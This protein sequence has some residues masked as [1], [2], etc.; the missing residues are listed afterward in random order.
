MGKVIKNIVFPLL[1]L[2]G[3]WFFYKSYQLLMEENNRYQTIKGIDEKVIERL[4]IS[5]HIQLHY[6]AVRGEYASNW[7]SLFNFVRTDSIYTVQET[8]TIKKGPQG[9]ELIIERDTIGVVQAYDSLKNKLGG[10][11]LKDLE[12]IKF[13]PGHSKEK[14]VEFVLK[15]GEVKGL[16]VFEI[17]DP[18]PL[19]PI[20]RK[21][22]EKGGSPALK[23]GSMSSASIRGNWEY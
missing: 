23:V 7:D 19:N 12:T 5:R 1:T 11:V 17:S 21:P 15:S 14:Q 18:D 8:Q 13:A 9:D 20:R 22:K 2:A 6:L 3:C 10:I 4:K 16:S